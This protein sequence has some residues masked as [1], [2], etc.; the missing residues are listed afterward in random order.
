MSFITSHPG[1]ALTLHAALLSHSCLDAAAADLATRLAAIASADRVAIGLMEGAQMRMIALSH[2]VTIDARQDLAALISAAMEEA[3]DQ[4]ASI[5]YPQPAGQP[6]IIAAHAD[7]AS[8][9]GGSVF[10]IPLAVA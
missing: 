2:G 3:I 10:T 1:S 9:H 7:L 5:A 8:R 6:R 4:A